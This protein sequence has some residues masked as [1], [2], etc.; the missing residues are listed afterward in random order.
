MYTLMYLEFIY[1]M[2][3]CL[4]NLRLKLSLANYRL[5]A[6]Q[7]IVGTSSGA[8]GTISVSSG[9]SLFVM[10][11]EGTFTTNEYINLENTTTTTTSN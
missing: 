7:R 1:L 5:T 8:K 3:V 10:D 6:G 2:F 4:L 9:T 11:V